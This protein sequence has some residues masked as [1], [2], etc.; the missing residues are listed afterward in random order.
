MPITERFQATQEATPVARESS[1][2]ASLEKLAAVAAALPTSIITR[3]ARQQAQTVDFA[4]SN[5]K[6][7]PFPVYLGGAQVLE[8]YPVGP[9]GGVAFN[10]TLLSYN[11]NLEMGLNIDTAAVAEPSRLQAGLRRAFDE[12]AAAGT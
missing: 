1:G 11:G 7:A 4:T 10:L 2:T 9:T 5:V 6:A 12:L 3:L 8:N